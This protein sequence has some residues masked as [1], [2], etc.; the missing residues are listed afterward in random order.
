MYTKPEGWTPLSLGVVWRIPLVYLK[1]IGYQDIE[2]IK[3]AD[4]GIR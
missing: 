2:Q 4:H 1:E 3:L